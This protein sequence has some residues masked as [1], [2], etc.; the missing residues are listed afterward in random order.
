MLVFAGLGNPGAK[1]ANNRHNVGFMAA[2][3]I[4]R[5]HSFSP[6][7]KKFRAEIAEG[8]SLD[9]VYAAKPFAD[10]DA[11]VGGAERISKL[12]LPVY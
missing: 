5:R 8:K 7:A 6:W 4:A 10:L 11:K 9:D 1:Y 12:K 3:A 2:D